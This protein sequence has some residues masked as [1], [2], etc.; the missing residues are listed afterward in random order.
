MI[1]SVLFVVILMCMC[2]VG[3]GYTRYKW[4]RGYRIGYG[5]H[6][7]ECWSYCGLSWVSE[8]CKIICQEMS[9]GKL[10]KNSV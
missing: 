7:K 10:M 9:N 2:D 8:L 1:R 3:F 5:C 6:Y 4:M